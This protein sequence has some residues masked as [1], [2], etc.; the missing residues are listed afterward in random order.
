[1]KTVSDDSRWLSSDIH[2]KY[3][4]KRKSSPNEGS[5]DLDLLNKMLGKK[6]NYILPK[7]GL[8]AIYYG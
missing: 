1:M 8:M 5:K 2:S 6:S 3:E 7:S 4:L